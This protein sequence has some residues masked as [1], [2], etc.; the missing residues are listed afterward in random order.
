MK[1]RVVLTSRWFLCAGFLVLVMAGVLVSDAQSGTVCGPGACISITPPTISGGRGSSSGS[2]GG[3]TAPSGP[4]PQQLQQQQQ[5]R[6][7]EAMHDANDTGVGLFNRGDWANAITY[8]QEALEQN[9]DDPVILE[10]LRRAQQAKAREEAESARAHGQAASGMSLDAASREAQ[11]VF[12]RPGERAPTSGDVV[13]ARG[14]GPRVQ[15]PPSLANHPEIRRL[16]DQRSGFVNQLRRLESQLESVRQKK[17][18]GEGNR[19]DL[20]VQEAKAKQE[21]S[22][23]TNQIGAV[24]VQTESFVIN[25]T[26]QSTPQR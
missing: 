3:S 12:D 24:D 7:E 2:S 8:F 17:A 15:I 9:P 4:T 21:I 18:R 16:Q 6:R 10:N 1:T 5:Q 22:N 23:V 25:M 19:G 14:L 20:D 13:D 11:R 26:R